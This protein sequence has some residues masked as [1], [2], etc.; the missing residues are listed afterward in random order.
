[1][2]LAI[3]SDIHA[4]M[5]AFDAVLKDIHKAG[6][7]AVISL[8]DN[9]GYGPEPEKVV[10]YLKKHRIP[11]VLGN[12]EDAICRPSQVESFNI[13]ARLSI[14]KTMEWLSEETVS[15]IKQLPKYM[16][17]HQCRFV[18]GAPPDSPTVYMFEL[19]GMDNKH[20]FSLFDEPICFLGHTHKLEMVCFDGKNANRKKL[21]M[22]TYKLEKNNQYIINVGSV[23]QPR[24]ENKHAKYV[25]WD[26]DK[27]VID[28][29]YVAYD[30]ARVA[31][32]IKAAGLPL[33]NA[34]RLW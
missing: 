31:E 1:M 30:V 2:K 21:F 15:Y 27:N 33:A 13:N 19:L 6:P 17:V 26:S 8:G 11:S 3:L 18:H 29:R 20:I 32:K 24:D 4:N 28:V 12:H 5:E 16:L 23:G 7:D 10:S 14:L 34:D 22:G 25:I 9:I